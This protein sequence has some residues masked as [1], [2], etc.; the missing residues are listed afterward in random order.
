MNSMKAVVDA[1]RKNPALAVALVTALCTALAAFGVPVTDEQV[2]SLGGLV[3]AALA[4]VA[5]KSH[6]KRKRKSVQTTS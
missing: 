6:R 3:T 4:L 5:V 1:V 2:A